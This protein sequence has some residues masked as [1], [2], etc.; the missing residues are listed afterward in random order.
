MAL[1]PQLQ[2]ILDM[3]SQAGMPPLE[4]LQPSQ[5]R[6]MMDMPMG[7]EVEPVAGV[8]NRII[9]GPGS[10]LAVRIYTPEGEGP[11]RLIVFFHGGG[12]VLGTLDTH[13]GLAR[14]LA[15]SAGAVVVSVDY[16]LAPEHPF[17]AAPEDCYAATVWAA[18]HAASLGAR[19]ETLAVGGDSAGGALAA[20]VCQMS[21]DRDGPAIAYQLLFY[22]VTDCDFE[23][24]SYRD[25]GEGYFLTRSMM[26]WFWDHYLAK[27]ADADQ[28][29]CAPLR[30]ANLSGLPPASVVT[31][32]YDPLRDEGEAY[33]QALADAGVPVHT[34]RWD[35]MIHGFASFLDVVDS[36]R[37]AV[38][39]ATTE[40]RNTV[41]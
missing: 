4:S 29:Y 11:H 32:E 38:G 24:V 39:Q 12:F 20:S 30:R 19:P 17:P 5:A 28:P 22:P 31:A 37:G 36:A 16:R 34:R 18:Q 7:T 10:D 15:N 14:A 23:T 41:G 9:P 2:P 40:Y 13:D 26:Q 8:D 33:G 25:N 35:G 1:H 6:A 27:P 3:M 21:A